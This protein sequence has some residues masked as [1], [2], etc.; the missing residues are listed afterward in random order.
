MTGRAD[1]PAE[2]VGALLGGVELGDQG[3]SPFP[4][5]PYAR[6][7]RGGR[8]RSRQLRVAG[9]EPLDLLQLD[10]VPRR[11]ADH[12]VESAL[13]TVVLPAAPD[14]GEGGFPV[15]EALAVGYGGGVGPQ[16]FEGG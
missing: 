11:I 16:V 1:E 10:A 5:L 12:G 13:W 3:R 15:Q 14:A 2:L 4:Q 7:S 6:P 8:R 9:R